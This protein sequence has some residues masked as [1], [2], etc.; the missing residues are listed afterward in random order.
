[1]YVQDADG[2]PAPQATVTVPTRT[3]AAPVITLGTPDICPYG[4]N[5]ATVPPQYANYWWS[6]N[7]GYLMSGDGTNSIRFSRGGYPGHENEPITITLY[8]QD[9]D[10][11]P[12][13]QATVSVPTRT[14]AAPVITLGTPDICPYGTNTATV[15]AQYANYWWSVHIAS[16]LSGDGTTSTTF[17]AGG[18]LPGSEPGPITI[19]LYVQ[20]ANGCPAPQS[21]VTVPIRTIPAPV[22]TLAT[23]DICKYGTNT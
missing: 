23:P 10:G 12:A 11:C 4:T 17:S 18:G 8:V 5:T 22:I 7:N 3:I 6:L 20:D 14:I 15:P 2:C 19:T 1:L 21:T 9:A 13:P 16:H